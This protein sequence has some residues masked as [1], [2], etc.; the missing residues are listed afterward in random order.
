MLGEC[1]DVLHSPDLADSH[2]STDN[3]G[4]AAPGVL[5][6]LSWSM[7]G[8]TGDRMPREVAYRMGVFSAAERRQFP[9]IVRPFYG[10]I[11]LRM[12]YLAT[13][14]DR[15]PGVDGADLVANMFG[16]VPDTMNFAPTMRRYPVIVYRLP[17]A[18]VAAPRQVRRRAAVIDAWWRSSIA[19]LPDLSR[20]EC[21]AALRDAVGRF[22]ESLTWHS[23]ALL[24][25]V[26]PMLV[27][28]TKLVE[29]A[30]VGDVGVLSGTGGAEM[31]IVSDIWLASRGAMTVAEVAANHGFHG[32]LEGEVSSRVW[33]EDRAPLE[34]MIS[35]YADRPDSEDPVQRERRA[36]AQLPEA[37]REVLAAL[38]SSRRL[39]ARLLLTLAERMLPLRGVGKRSFLQSLDVARGAARRL[40]EHL[41]AQGELASVDDVF[42][43]TVDELTGGLP[44][45]A[46]D[47]VN[48]RLERGR[49]YVTLSL[50]G[51]WRGVPDTTVSTVNNDG[52][53]TVRDVG[54][55]IRGLGVSAG[56]VE[57]RVR[58]VIDPSFAEVEPGE[59]LV[60][61]TTDP[62]WASIMFLSSALVVDIGGPLSHAAV[63]ARELGLPCVVNTRTGS[64]VL[65]T[66]D[67]V[68]VDG[69][70]GT[71]E[72]LERAQDHL[73][74][75][76]RR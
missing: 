33:R 13:V 53:A 39:P 21:V 52:K 7:W 15:M 42:Q 46:R 57:G 55:T 38:P 25:V 27:Q 69:N 48:R 32:P 62:S 5:T 17:R 61:C 30:G 2:W 65:R 67:R 1:W 3:V 20:S 44:A 43:L 75:Q 24:A 66:G 4:E 18:I 50:P 70:T 59:V 12:E 23:L 37:Q 64:G 41:V 73:A 54:E 71:V 6:P 63:V 14:G 45:D 58:V 31:A 10:R 40:G 26:Q 56:V 60:A 51:N 9:P 19:A 72:V 11:A 68:R 74:A 36:S 28:L 8:M 34:R 22:D 47:L 35:S 29:R 49:E 76:E 16:R